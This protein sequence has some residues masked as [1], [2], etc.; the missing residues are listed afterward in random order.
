MKSINRLQFLGSATMAGLGMVTA[1]AVALGGIN[2]ITPLLSGSNDHPLSV[3]GEIIY[4]MLDEN[5]Y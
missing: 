5:R 3:K 4:P 1:P 2:H